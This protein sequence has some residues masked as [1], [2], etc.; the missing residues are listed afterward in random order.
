M[1][2]VVLLILLLL[3]V[4]V[5][6]FL[7]LFGN[8]QYNIPIFYENGVDT[9]F[10]DCEFQPEAFKVPEFE[11]LLLNDEKYSSNEQLTNKVIY[12][13]QSIEDANSKLIKNNLLRVQSS[14]SNWETIEF[15]M[16]TQ[17]RDYDDTES[18]SIKMANANPIYLNQLA[19]CGL[20][21]DF[22]A[23]SKTVNKT[24]VVVD[25]KNQIRGYYNGIGDEEIDRLLVE[26]RILKAN[27]N[28]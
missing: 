10:T 15:L 18:G 25:A 11:L 21:I 5:Y 4:L 6:L 28:D 19:R 22:D 26:L 8:N 17:H 13:T 20:V 3:P 14:M 24:I 9:T 2:K 27:S 1:K 7:R 23:T 16:I 12:V